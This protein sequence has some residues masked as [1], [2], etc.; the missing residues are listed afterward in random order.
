MNA[1]L[2][3]SSILF[4]VLLLSCGGETKNAPADSSVK[5]TAVVASTPSGPD[6]TLIRETGADD[7]GMKQYV[8]AFLKAG[9]KRDQDSATRATIQ[10]GHMAN[11]E[12]LAKEGK[13]V[14]AGPFMDDSEFAGIFIFDT[15]PEEAKALTEADPAVQSGRLIMELHPWYGSAALV[16][17]N[18]LHDK[19]QTKT[20]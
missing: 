6:T 1:K 19:L 20:F 12:K 17:M 14:M 13:L 5:D 16:K 2:F 4:S 11:I 18:A 7:Y 10:A 9:P 15:T 8:M 3:L